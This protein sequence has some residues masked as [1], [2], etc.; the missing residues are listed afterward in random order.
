MGGKLNEE[1]KKLI[2]TALTRV[3]KHKIG[4]YLTV[5]SHFEFEDETELK[6]W[7]NFINNALQKS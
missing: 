1:N 7:K 5:V 2:Y 4:S 3:K 6:N